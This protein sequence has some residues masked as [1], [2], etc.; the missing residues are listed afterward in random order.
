MAPELLDMTGGTGVDW[1]TLGIL[2]HEMLTGRSP[3]KSETQNAVLRELRSK[4]PV[5]LS[6]ELS[7]HGRSIISGLVT[8]N[9]RKRLGA[10]GAMELKSHPFFWPRLKQSSDWKKLLERQIKPPIRPCKMNSSRKTVKAVPK[11]RGSGLRQSAERTSFELSKAEAKAMKVKMAAE[12]AQFQK[13]FGTSNFDKSQRNLAIKA[14]AFPD[15]TNEGSVGHVFD[16]FVECEG[17]PT[18]REKDMAAVRALIER[19]RR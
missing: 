3:W 18:I 1:W 9:P 8:R 4:E 6:P 11:G 10:R 17:G 12:K 13:Q 19:D 16:G 2:M 5:K 15:Q 7:N 14:V